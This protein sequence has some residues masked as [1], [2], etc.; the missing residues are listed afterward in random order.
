[1]LIGTDRNLFTTHS[2]VRRRIVAL[3]AEHFDA[4]D[5]I[6][7]SAKSHRISDV[8]EDGKFHA[9]PT[10][11]QSRLLYG[12]DALRIAKRIR[13]PDIV[14][15]QD[16]FETGL[17]A[18]FI[19]RMYGVPL[20][21][22]VHTDFLAPAYSKHSVL[23]QLRVWIAGYVLRRASGGYAVSQK[24]RD[25]IVQRYGLKVPFSVLPI[26]IDLRRFEALAQN[27][28]MLEVV[29]ATAHIEKNVVWI[30][31]MEPEK[32]PMLALDAFMQARRNGHA[33]KLQFV[34]SGSLVEPLKQKVK[35]AKLSENV[36]FTAAFVDPLPYYAQADLLLVTSEYEGFGMVIIEALA[37]RVSVLSRDVGIARE[38][39]AEIA[40]DDFTTSLENWLSSE[41]P[42][43]RLQLKSYANEGDYLSQVA[44]CYKHIVDNSTS[45][46]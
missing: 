10:N 3:A 24:I 31:R 4:I 19:S 38:A 28:A 13:R 16:P 44:D 22:E 42:V 14:S 46:S 18:L 6:V 45:P 41:H 29:P 8:I 33:V 35:D 40:T 20:A 37:A 39:G 7:F 1:M 30:G 23:N 2:D 36:Q 5:S 43:A 17:A 15:A 26:Y 34:G 27:K 12:W 9:H 21:V 25:S 32:N 11:S